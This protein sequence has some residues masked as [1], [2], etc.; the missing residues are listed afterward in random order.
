MAR[1]LYE[2]RGETQHKLQEMINNARDQQ[3]IEITKWHAFF[4]IRDNKII[5][6]D[7]YSLKALKECTSEDWRSIHA[8]DWVERKELK[9]DYFG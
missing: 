6:L 8:Q 3:M 9:I 2:M 4:I 7:E 1:G 5:A